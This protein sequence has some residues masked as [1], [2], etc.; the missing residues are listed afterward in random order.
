M[1][2]LL[3]FNLVWGLQMPLYSKAIVVL[4]FMFRAP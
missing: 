4:A 3:P 1:L 2:L